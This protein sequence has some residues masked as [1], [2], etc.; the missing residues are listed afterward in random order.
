MDQVVYEGEPYTPGEY[1]PFVQIDKTKRTNPPEKGSHTKKGTT[2]QTEGSPMK[3][4]PNKKPLRRSKR[5]KSNHANFS[6][7]PKGSYLD[8]D[9]PARTI[10][11]HSTLRRKGKDGC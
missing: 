1:D 11:Y 2:L 9:N 5:L 8:K 7:K 3:A 6:I 10:G 4:H